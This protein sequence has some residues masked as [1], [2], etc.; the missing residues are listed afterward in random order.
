ME[1]KAVIFISGGCFDSYA[2]NTAITVEVVD[3]DCPMTA[4]QADRLL[5]NNSFLYDDEYIVEQI[6]EH[7]ARSASPD[8]DE[9]VS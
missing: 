9:E 7:V 8:D 6:K 5:A 1:P 3:F 4:E 2:T